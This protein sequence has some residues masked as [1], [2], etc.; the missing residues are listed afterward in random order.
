M[1]KVMEYRRGRCFVIA[2]WSWKQINLGF[3]ISRWGINFDLI[4]LWV[5][6][7]W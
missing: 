1:S 7:E 3:G 2:G 5:S 4:W 6:I